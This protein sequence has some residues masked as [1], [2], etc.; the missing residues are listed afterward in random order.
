[1]SS[2]DDY[3][4]EDSERKSA[5][6]RAASP[7][8]GDARTGPWAMQ[9]DSDELNSGP[10]IFARQVLEP[11]EEPPDG[12]VVEVLDRSGRFVGHALFNSASDIRLRMLSRGRRTDLAQP[13]QFLLKR[14][15]AADDIRR[16]VLR[17]H[18]HSDAYRVAHAEGDDLPGLI[19]DRLGP[20]LVCEHHS[21]GFWRLRGEIEW[22]LKQLY[23]ALE[24]VQRVPK[25]A[26]RAEG[27]EP[28]DPERDIEP[29][30]IHEHG[31]TF[32]IVPAGGHKTGWF[33]D[34]RENRRAV[35]ELAEGRDVLDLCCN[36]GGFGL[37]AKLRGARRVR[38]VD[39]DEVVLE[40]AEHSAAL[41]HLDVE[42]IHADAF[43][44]LRS[45]KGSD[46]RPQLVIV[47]PHKLIASRERME[48]G[49][50]KY[51]D[52]NTLALEVVRSGGL[53]ATFSCSGLLAE[54]AFIGMLFQAARRAGRGVRLLQQ[55]GAAPDHP[56]R[57]DFSRSRY[58][59]GALLFVE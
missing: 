26:A 50:R 6:R 58:L 33:C 11:E 53:I 46:D 9:L 32:E 18:D 5:P 57:P 7:P 24:V 14:L 15:K 59:K 54:P 38:C 19:V 28:E 56:Q 10:W 12:S 20:Y 36:Q 44:F 43:P 21:L 34:Q 47:D 31:L 4:D 25:M 1:M 23:P 37:A 22:A 55:F 13:R 49:L 2:D 41:N 27:F 30:L 51:A 29:C 48:E 8:R 45:M 52:L 16:K 40:R 35:S 3:D 42:F 17:I 39:L